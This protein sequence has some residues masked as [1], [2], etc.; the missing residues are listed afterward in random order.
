[1]GLNQYSPATVTS[2][3]IQR[4]DG[5][6]IPQQLRHFC[7]SFTVS[8]ATVLGIPRKLPELPLVGLLLLL[9]PQAPSTRYVSAAR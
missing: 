2:N 3:R 5:Y 6:F 9:P 7:V 4:G 8:T 1:M